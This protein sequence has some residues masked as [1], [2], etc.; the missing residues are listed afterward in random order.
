MTGEW[1]FLP[2][3]ILVGAGSLLAG[4][5]GAIVQSTVVPIAIPEGDNPLAGGDSGK[6]CLAG[7]LLAGVVLSLA[8]VTLP[9]AL[10]L[11]WAVDRGTLAIVTLLA[12]ATLGVGRAVFEFGIRF[13]A[14]PVATQGAGDLRGRDPQPLSLAGR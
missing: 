9:V 7:V 12:A 3:G 2:A 14:A 5:G 8:I 4:T 13:A 11:L 1:R 6:G 10:A